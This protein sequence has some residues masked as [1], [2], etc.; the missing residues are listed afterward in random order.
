[1]YVCVID[2]YMYQNMHAC[3]DVW[4][5]QWSPSVFSPSE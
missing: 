5:P 1:M 4:Q 3:T 2:I